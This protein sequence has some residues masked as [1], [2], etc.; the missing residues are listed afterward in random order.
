VWVCYAAPPSVARSFTANLRGGARATP[1]STAGGI[2][3]SFEIP[4][5]AGLRWM[6]RDVDGLTVTTAYLPLL[7]DSEP[8]VPSDDVRFIFMPPRWWVDARAEEL[9]SFGDGA[10]DVARAALF[11]AYLD[12][13]TRLPILQDLAFQ[14][15]LF[16][17]AKEEPWVHRPGATRWDRSVLY[18]EGVEAC[19]L[20][21]PLALRVSHAEL[22]AFL[23]REV[24]RYYEEE[25]IPRGKARIGQGGGLLPRPCKP[26]EQLQLELVF[27]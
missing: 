3:D 11:A 5:S 19:G 9:R 18:Q 13:R 23:A 22:E 1:T 15:R 17:A 20:D 21:L 8:P 16:E 2:E 4:K 7:F 26:A 10:P 6:A 27:A 14:R 25:V 12:R 24:R